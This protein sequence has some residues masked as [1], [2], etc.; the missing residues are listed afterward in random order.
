MWRCYSFLITRV[1]NGITTAA[2]ICIYP[3][4]TGHKKKFKGE[5]ILKCIHYSLIIVFVQ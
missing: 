3:N 1:V 5:N 4:F 2:C